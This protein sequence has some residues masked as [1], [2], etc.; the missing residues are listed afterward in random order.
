MGRE[1][2]AHTPRT[3]RRRPAVGQNASKKRKASEF[4]GESGNKIKEERKTK[5]YTPHRTRIDRY[6]YEAAVYTDLQSRKMSLYRP[7]MR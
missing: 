4:D 1:G 3:L 2:Q 7:L 5:V 6:S